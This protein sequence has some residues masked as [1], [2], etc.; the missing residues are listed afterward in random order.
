[1]NGLS[2][3]RVLF[4]SLCALFAAWTSAEPPSDA[5]PVALP[6]IADEN[7][8]PEVRIVETDRGTVYEYSTGGVVYMVRIMPAEGPP[9]YLLDTDGDGQLD[10]RYRDPNNI[11]IPQWLLYQW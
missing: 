5:P 8:E 9:Y 4:G 11:A 2:L 3:L 6:Q 7:L 10:V 1:M